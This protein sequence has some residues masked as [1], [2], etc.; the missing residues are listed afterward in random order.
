[1]ANEATILVVDDS[2][3]NL[4]VLDDMLE[5]FGFSVLLA[6]NGRRCL[7][8]AKKEK[9]DLILLD[10]IMPD[11]DGYETCRHLKADPETHQIPVLFLSGLSDTDTK[12]QAL[13]AGGVDYVSKPFQK[14]ELLA[15]VRTHVELSRL[16]TGLEQEVARKTQEIRSLLQEL[17][18]SYQKAQE[19]SVIKSEFLHN[20]SHEFRTPMNIILGMT[21]ELIEDTELDEEQ[22]EMAQD[23]LNA[24]QQLMAIL[25]NMLNFSQQFESELKQESKDFQLATVIDEVLGTFSHDQNK[26]DIE[27][28]TLLDEPLR[29]MTFH[30][31]YD[32]LQD[33]LSKIVDN[34]FK[35]TE[36]G[37]VLIEVKQE[38]V[39]GARHTLLFSV[40][41]TGIGVPE[42]KLDSLFQPFTQ[43][44][45]SSTREHDGMGLG[46]AL[47][48]T[49]VDR[50]EGKIGAHPQEGGGSVFWFRIQLV[51]VATEGEDSSVFNES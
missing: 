28:K 3:V 10:V 32:Y 1:M 46:L 34:A 11:W 21:E 7:N 35:F 44:D 42:D 9:P 15:R 50:M 40:A 24:G 49:Y 19:A 20:I 13:E 30:G 45:A 37:K 38:K 26:L 29:S 16:R 33:I 12:V 31:N 43:A 27:V 48:K 39:D 23:V 4:A 36:Q 22:A 6:N 2:L 5:E 41:D 8:V 17:K 47:A 25:T 14:S 18:I 51:S